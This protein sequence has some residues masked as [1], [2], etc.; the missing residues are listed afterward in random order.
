ML[1]GHLGEF[2]RDPIAFLEMCARDYGDVVRLRF[3]YKNVFLF[4]DPADIE[5][6]LVTHAG[7]F[8]KSVGYRTP[9]M[10]RLFGDGLLT[11]EGEIWAR[12]RRLAQPAF[13]RDR[14]ASYAKTIV[15]F[16]ERN[17]GTW[18]IGE[19][20]PIHI[21]MMRLTTEI[22]VKTLFNSAVP[23]EIERLGEASKVVMD[24]FT[25]QWTGWR[26]LTNLFPTVGSRRFEQV[27]RDL[28][29]FIYRL[30]CE[31][32][33]SGQDLGDLLSM[34]LGALDGDGNGMSDRQLRDELTTI[35]VAGLD[36]IALTLA[37][38]FYLLSQN[39]AVEQDLVSDVTSV[40]A[41]RV[42][43]FDDLP[44]LTYTEAVVKET[45]RLYPASWIVGR[46]ATHDCDLRGQR[47]RR[48][49]SV[50]VSQWLNHRDPRWFPNPEK[51][52]PERWRNDEV[53][54]LPKFAYFPFGRGPRI[55]IG[56]SFAMM[57]ATLVLAT[58]VQKFRL[59]SEPGYKVVPR[60]AITLQPREGV[61]LKVQSRA[62][63]G[64]ASPSS[65]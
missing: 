45:M 54:K 8:R 62:S 11:S 53:K 5:F 39:E 48:G 61:F 16:T 12:Q 4:N 51:F 47:I 6:F 49:D 25:Q 55:C 22:V 65:E 63:P 26:F 41:G 33:A 34:L 44:R 31:R 64:E 60:P 21:D 18:K 35:M 3:I 38:A 57:E 36:T 10:R 2:G 9:L 7:N 27:M 19:T 20:R 23:P 43:T 15:D 59:T 32:R 37:W 58:V 42:P 30:I 13:H 46:E 52:E 56:N 14:I 17:I 50:L 1:L 28:D 24:R 29:S 40:L